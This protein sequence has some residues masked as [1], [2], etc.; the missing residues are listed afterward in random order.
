[1]V[2]ELRLTSNAKEI[3]GWIKHVQKVRI[4]ASNKMLTKRV[5][6]GI[7]NSAKRNVKERSVY[8]GKKPGTLAGSIF[9]VALPTGKG[10]SGYSVVA[11]APYAMFVEKGTRPHPIPF[12]PV[13]KFWL[14]GQQ[15]HPGSR[16]MNFMRDAFNEEIAVINKKIDMA[17]NWR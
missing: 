12:N 13:L 17:Y 11:N 6:D 14:T 4:P 8:H 16:P 9:T 10:R 3:V 7:K 5:A 1:M 15:T 2:V